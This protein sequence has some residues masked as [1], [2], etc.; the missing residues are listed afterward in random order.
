M[1]FKQYIRKACTYCFDAIPQSDAMSQLLQKS[2]KRKFHT[3]FHRFPESGS[4]NSPVEPLAV[5]H[6]V[7]A[8]PCCQR[9]WQIVK[10]E[11]LWKG[12]KFLQVPSCWQIVNA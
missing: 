6:C 7:A 2:V 12:L 5:L 9:A 1:P 3:F 8:K 11:R 4:V 10:D